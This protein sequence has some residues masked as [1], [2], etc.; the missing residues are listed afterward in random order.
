MTEDNAT[1]P[2]NILSRYF[3]GSVEEKLSRARILYSLHGQS[4]LAS[5]EIRPAL[6]QLGRALDRLQRQMETMTLPLQCA[7]CASRTDGCCSSAMADNSDV[8]Q[9]LI[10]MLLQVEVRQHRHE[11]DLC[12]FLGRHG[13]IF[14]AKPIFCL[15][16]N[17]SHIREAATAKAMATLEHLTGTVLAAQTRLE[18]ILLHF[19]AGTS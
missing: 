18:G 19:L 14:P 16:Y 9:L 17:C 12:C 15:N 4:M 7:T 3:D 13:C 1:K 11:E 5:P 6:G 10:N 2:D 8:M